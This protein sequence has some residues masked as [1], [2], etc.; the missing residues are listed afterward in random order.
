ML[1]WIV[2]HGETEANTSGVLEGRTDGKLTVSGLEMANEVG[3]ALEGITFDLAFSSPLSRAVDTARRLLDAS[4]NGSLPIRVDDRLLEIDMGTWEGVHF[5]PGERSV[6]AEQIRLFFERPFVFQGFPGGENAREVCARTQ[7]FLRELAAAPFDKV[8]VSTHGFALRAMLNQLYADP[9]DFWQ[10]GVPLN[11]TVSI[12]EV[13]DGCLRLLAS[14][15][16]LYDQSRCVDRY[17]NY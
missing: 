4:G 2:R 9:S 10:G 11:C 14:D 6:D 7:D 12:V 5:L 16:I 15:E 13:T 3:A 17:S 8:L 1:I